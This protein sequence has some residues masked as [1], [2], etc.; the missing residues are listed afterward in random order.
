MCPVL[1]IAPGRQSAGLRQDGRMGAWAVSR[2]VPPRAAGRHRGRIVS[3]RGHAQS[4]TTLPD[5]PAH[6]REALR[7]IVRRQAV[8]DDLA[9]VEAALQHGD[10]LVPGLEHLAAVDALDGER[11]EHDRGPVDR[12]LAGRDAEH[13]DAA[14]HHHVFDHLVERRRRAR[15]SPARR[16]S[17]PPCRAGPSRRAGPPSATL[18][19]T[20][21]ATSAA[22]SSRV[23]FTSVMTTWRAPTWRRDG[24]GHDADRA[25]AGDQHVLADDIEGE[26]GVHGVAERIEDGAD[27][28][29]DRVGQ[30]HD[31]EGRDPQILGEGAGQ[32]DADALGLGIEVE[33]AGA[34]DWRLFMPTTGPRR[35]RAGRPSGA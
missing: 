1:S 3:P 17:P 10:H 31:V 34:R 26:R 32:V 12:A 24:R 25:G 13:G 5:C 6:R 8:G 2:P 20:T 22:S 27:L 4:S 29:V 15:T 11:L 7:E 33:V 35:R 23:G 16:R 21:S 19:G 9:H 14:A 28:V 18:T 30:R